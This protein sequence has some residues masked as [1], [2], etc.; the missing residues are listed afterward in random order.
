LIIAVIR[1]DLD[2]HETKLARVLGTADFEPASEEAIRKAGAVAGYGSPVA[3]AG[4]T[5]VIVDESIPAARNL[6]AGANKPGYH[7]LNVNYGR[8][9]TADQV[10]D[11]ATARTGDPCPQCGAPLRLERAIELGHIFKL[12]TY[13]SASMGATYLDADGEEQ[14]LVMG[15]Y[16]IGL[17]RLMAAIAEEYH[18]DKGLTWPPSVAPADVYLITLAGGDGEIEGM[19]EELYTDLRGAGFAVIFDDRDDRAGVKF[20]DADLLGIPVRLTISSRARDRG[21]VEIK[22]R[23]EDDAE[24]AAPGELEPAIRARLRHP[25]H[26]Q[27]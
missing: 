22:A 19:A 6:V 20:N 11:I 27:V 26:L 21:G 12:G 5:T 16:G 14:T 2:I 13:Y 8:D 23:W 4:Q 1:G 3:L 24:I 15:S 18:D 17:G 25:K 7:L 9:Y 10:V